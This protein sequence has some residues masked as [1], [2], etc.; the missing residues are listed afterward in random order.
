MLLTSFGR[1]SKYLFNQTLVV[2]PNR[3]LLF[4]HGKLIRLGINRSFAAVAERSDNVEHDKLFKRIDLEIRGHDQEVLSSYFTFVNN[5]CDHLDIEKSKIEQPPH[6]SW[7]LTT[8]KDKFA[9]KKYKVQYETRTYIKM[10]YVKYLTGSTASTF[11]EY[12]E[13]N[14]PEG[15]AMKVTYTE[16]CSLPATI[17]SSCSG[18]QSLQ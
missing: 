13:R 6:E 8:L 10:M 14:I 7:L 4:S 9:K 11:L 18:S 2:S 12:I 3:T 1:F 17:T 16:M 15:V 5:V